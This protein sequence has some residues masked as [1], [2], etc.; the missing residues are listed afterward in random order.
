MKSGFQPPGVTIKRVSNN[1]I[2]IFKIGAGASLLKLAI[3]KHQKL[4][5]KEVPKSDFLVMCPIA[6][7]LLISESFSDKKA[8]FSLK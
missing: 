1:F 2:V 3:F 8:K 6:I 4:P 7:V 5:S